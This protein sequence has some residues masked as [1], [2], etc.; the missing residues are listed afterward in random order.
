LAGVRSQLDV[1]KADAQKMESLR[2]LAQARYLYLLSKLR[3]AALAGSE[4]HDSI[5]EINGFLLG[6]QK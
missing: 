3:L 2:D 5:T 1:L 4:M 6:N